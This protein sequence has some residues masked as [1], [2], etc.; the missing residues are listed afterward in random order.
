MQK[1]SVFQNAKT[2]ESEVERWFM[3]I[4]EFVAPLPNTEQAT[5]MSSGVQIIQTKLLFE[6]RDLLIEI[7]DNTNQPR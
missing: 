6:I 2:D 1:P 4:E 5:F 7:R 3:E